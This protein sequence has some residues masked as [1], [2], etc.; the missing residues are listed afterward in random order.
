MSSHEITH[1][2][3]F[4]LSLDLQEAKTRAPTFLHFLCFSGGVKLH[5]K[6]FFLG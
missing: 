6:L 2:F 5:L 4:I 1:P 3:A